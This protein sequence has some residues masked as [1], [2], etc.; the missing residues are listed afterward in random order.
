M[1]PV[2]QRSDEVA[3]NELPRRLYNHSMV[4]SGLSSRDAL[5]FRIAFLCIDSWV[6]AYREHVTNVVLRTACGL[7]DAL[8]P[9]L[10]WL[11]PLPRDLTT[12]ANVLASTEA[13]NSHLVE[14]SKCTRV[15]RAPTF[16]ARLYE[17][18]HN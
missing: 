2:C 1:S 6:P 15:N 13:P 3:G 8:P 18:A 4:L 9:V 11:R 17:G 5:P 10:I 7:D 16:G 14:R 12:Q